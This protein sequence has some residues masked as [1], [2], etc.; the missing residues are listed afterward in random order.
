MEQNEWIYIRIF[1][2][3]IIVVELVRSTIFT[4]SLYIQD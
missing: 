3:V 1:L 4:F 2:R